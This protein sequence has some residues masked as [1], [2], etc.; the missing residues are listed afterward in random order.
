[1]TI[2]VTIQLKVDYLEY[3]QC[4]MDNGN[5]MVVGWLGLAIFK[6][7]GVCGSQETNV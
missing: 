2:V 6:D 3:V 4:A 5:G 7:K 1:M